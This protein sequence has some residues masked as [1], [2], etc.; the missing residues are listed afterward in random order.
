MSTVSAL[1]RVPRMT[2]G[3]CRSRIEGALTPLKGVAQTAVDLKN[4][5]VTVAYDPTT[6]DMARIIEEIED[7][8]Y[9]VESSR[10]VA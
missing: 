10:K 2:C 1:F 8:G 5:V 3:G 7:T 9:A 4:K 6:I